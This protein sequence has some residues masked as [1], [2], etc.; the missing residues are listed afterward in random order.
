VGVS[1]ATVWEIAIKHALARGKPNHMPLSGIGAL[2]CFRKAGYEL[3][4]VTAEHAAAAERP[5]RFMPIPSTA[6]LLPK[7]FRAI[8]SADA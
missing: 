7:P 8:A 3:L 5:N 2:G 1:A 4:A 6:C